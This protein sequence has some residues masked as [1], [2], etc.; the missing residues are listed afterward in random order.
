MIEKK[1]VLFRKKK[2]QKD[3]LYLRAVSAEM[4]GGI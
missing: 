1:A 2:N 4:L 3:F